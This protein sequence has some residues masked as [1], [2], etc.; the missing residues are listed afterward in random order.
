MKKVEQCVHVTILRALARRQFPAKCPREQRRQAKTQGAEGKKE[1]KGRWDR[2]QPVRSGERR[3]L[4]TVARIA[5]SGLLPGLSSLLAHPT[6]LCSKMKMA[7]VW[8]SINVWLVEIIISFSDV[9]LHLIGK[10]ITL[11]DVLLFL[12]KVFHVIHPPDV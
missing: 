11:H 2:D 8:N 3:E 7:R 4:T 6:W 5:Q 9:P 12:M 1:G 10:V